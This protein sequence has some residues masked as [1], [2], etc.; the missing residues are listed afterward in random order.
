MS[1]ACGRPSCDSLTAESDIE[2]LESV[3]SSSSNPC[4]F[5]FSAIN[6]N[7]TFL[8]LLKCIKNTNFDPTVKNVSGYIII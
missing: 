8:L 4:L 5:S 3:S 7:V 6:Y 1:H 2:P